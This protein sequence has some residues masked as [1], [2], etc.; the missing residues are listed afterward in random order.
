MKKKVLVCGSAGFLMSNFMRYVLYRSKEF[1]I[2]S[3]DKLIKP[4]DF[5]RV[6][7]NRNHKFYIGDITDEY[8][9]DRLIHIEKPDWIING[10]GYFSTNLPKR[11]E[12]H[13][14]TI[15]E[16]AILLSKYKIPT[17]QLGQDPYVDRFGYN[18]MAAQFVLQNDTMLILPNCFG[19]RQ[20]PVAGLAQMI[21][22]ILGSK[23]VFTHHQRWPWVYAEDVASLIWYIIEKEIKGEIKMPPLGFMNLE[24]MAQIVC[25]ELKENPK[26]IEVKQ[27]VT[28]FD[29]G[30]WEPM[31]YWPDKGSDLE[32][33]A[34]DSE[35]LESAILKTVSWYK[36]NSWALR[37]V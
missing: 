10:V 25:G 26:V 20:K 19:L 18:H 27:D 36:A 34:P 3:V 35:N 14:K 37:N 30:F 15:V 12:L 17:I 31:C 11:V 33:W 32:G 23:V 5:Q 24:T 6:Y 4:E 16:S 7:L 28:P 13:A 2:V 22:G 8:F 9:M 29:N 21:G 1:E